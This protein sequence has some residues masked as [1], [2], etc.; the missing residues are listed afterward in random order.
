MSIWLDEYT[1]HKIIHQ[2]KIHERAVTLRDIGRQADDEKNPPGGYDCPTALVL[3][4]KW[5][6]QDRLRRAMAITTWGKRLRILA[7]TSK[8][9]KPD[10]KTPPPHHGYPPLPSTSRVGEFLWSL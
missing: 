7:V 3:V 8:W 1:F 2:V 4:F 5:N 6:W 10:E 9:E